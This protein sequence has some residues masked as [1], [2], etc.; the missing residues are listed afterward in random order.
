MA[1]PTNG[2]QIGTAIPNFRSILR[3][4]LYFEPAMRSNRYMRRWWLERASASIGT[5]VREMKAAAAGTGLQDY[6]LC[7]GLDIFLEAYSDKMNIPLETLQK[8]ST[9]KAIDHIF[10]PYNQ[11]APRKYVA[12]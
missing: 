9:D 4:I 10:Y 11:I 7:N 6:E 8:T 1:T 12:S 3:C 5:F 2:K